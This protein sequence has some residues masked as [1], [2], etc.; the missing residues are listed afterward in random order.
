[1]PEVLLSGQQLKPGERLESVNGRFHLELQASDGNL[2]IYAAFE[3]TVHSGGGLHLPVIRTD[4]K[5]IWATG[6][7]KIIREIDGRVIE[8][9]LFMQTDGNLVLR[10]LGIGE[11]GVM[12]KTDTEAFP[13][14]HLEM[15]DDGNLVVYD[16]IHI[17]RW[18]SNT[19]NRA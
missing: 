13:G 8:P 9:I 7:P 19:A 3:R 6:L 4:F 14:S 17:A 12:F 16:V 5:P 2:V 18:A 10:V 11:E 15:Q 1:M